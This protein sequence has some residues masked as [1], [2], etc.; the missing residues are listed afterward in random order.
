MKYETNFQ[1]YYNGRI[2][3]FCTADIP[4]QEHTAR[5]FCRRQELPDGSIKSCKDDYWAEIRKN[6][7]DIYKKILLYHK[8]VSRILMQLHQLNLPQITLDILDSTGIHLNR[9]LLH[10]EDE[11]GA[12]IFYFVD[13]A[14]SVHPTFN[15]IKIFKHE[16]ELF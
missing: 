9:C 6:E 8:Q 13:Y 16:K 4:D 3:L 14:I 11:T 15:N 7:H 2:C 10:Q 1:T 12:I 5:I